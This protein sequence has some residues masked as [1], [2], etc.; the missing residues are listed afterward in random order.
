MHR[1]K[2]TRAV[3]GKT[4]H[5][6]TIGIDI[7]RDILVTC[8]YDRTLTEHPVDEFPN[9]P[10]GLKVLVERCLIYSPG[11]VVLESTVNFVFAYFAALRAS[12]DATNK[13]YPCPPLDE[14]HAA[15]RP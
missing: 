2:A 1:V 11:M 13:K 6:R 9:T 15:T 4:L 7:D 12:E 10:Q 5:D 3:R 14:C 8:F